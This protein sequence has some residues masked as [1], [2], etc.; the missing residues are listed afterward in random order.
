MGKAVERKIELIKRL[1]NGK[2]LI[3]CGYCGCRKR[4]SAKRWREIKSCGCRSASVS[5]PNNPNR[6]PQGI[7]YF[8]RHRRLRLDYG[9][10]TDQTCADCG[11]P[12]GVEKEWSYEGGCRDELRDSDATSHGAPYCGNTSHT[13]CYI[14]RCRTGCHKEYDRLMREPIVATLRSAA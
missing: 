14:P 2:V 10:A 8:T 12:P 11:A 4:K 1:D 6:R 5:G 13:D 3:L 7:T 9:K